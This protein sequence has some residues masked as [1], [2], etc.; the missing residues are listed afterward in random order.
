MFRLNFPAQDIARPA[1]S[2]LASSIP[3]QDTAA[4][5]LQL[6][7]LLLLSVFLI[8]QCVTD[9]LA[10]LCLDACVT[11]APTSSPVTN[12]D[13]ATTEATK[14]RWTITIME[15]APWPLHPNLLW[16]M[17]DAGY[18]W[19]G[20]IKTLTSSF[21]FISFLILILIT[22]IAVHYLTRTININSR[23]TCLA[24]MPSMG[25]LVLIPSSPG[26]YSDNNAAAGVKLSGFDPMNL[27]LVSMDQ[28]VDPNAR[29]I[30]YGGAMTERTSSGKA[31]IVGR[32]SQK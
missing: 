7:I 24:L 22:S 32:S 17:L 28:N 4:P 26:S 23:T 21:I 18:D 25:P 19:R 16:Q 3:D 5:L 11:D 9:Y 13:E 1:A 15:P 12:E 30:Y 31:S 20:G 8:G 6:R 27:C 14:I 2:P 10:C 29:V